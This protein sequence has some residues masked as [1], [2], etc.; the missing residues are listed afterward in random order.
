MQT[1]AVKRGILNAL[2][3]SSAVTTHTDT[4][5]FSQR[6]PQEYARPFIVYSKTSGNRD[7]TH[8]GLSGLATLTFEIGCWSL[9]EST[10]DA[11]GD[12]VR[13][14]MCF[15][16]V[17]ATWGTLVVQSCIHQDESDQLFI[18]DGSEAPIYGHVLTV[19]ITYHEDDNP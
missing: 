16:S 3:S 12:A 1:S 2:L 9:S 18:P 14:A 5:I 19:A 15:G 4:R 13:E 10:T 6:V 8:D 17:G 7:T 11:M